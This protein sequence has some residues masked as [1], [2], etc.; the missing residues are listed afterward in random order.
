LA[1]YLSKG[2]RRIG[3]SETDAMGRPFPILHLARSQE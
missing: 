1:F 2:F 3:R